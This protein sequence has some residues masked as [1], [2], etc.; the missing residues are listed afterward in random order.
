MVERQKEDLKLIA[1]P[2]KSI[3]QKKFPE[4]KVEN[5]EKTRFIYLH[6]YLYGGVTTFTA[7]LIYKL[8]VFNSSSSISSRKSDIHIRQIPSNNA[9]LRC[10]KVSETKLREFGYGLVYQNVSPSILAKIK[11]PF[12]TIFKENYFFHVL[13][14]LNRRQRDSL[15]DITLVI[16]DHRDISQNTAPYVKNWR[17]VAIRKTV[18][19]YM[20]KRYGLDCAFLY[21]PFY[22][23]PVVYKPKR[24]GAVST[25]RISFEKNTD[26][27]IKANKILDTADVIKLY[28]C[29]S[30]VYV[31]SFLGGFQGDFGKYFYGIFDKSFSTLSE[32]LAEAK[33]VVDLSV[34]KHDGGGTQYSFLEAI[35]NDCALILHRKWIEGSDI[36][37]D[38]RDFKEGYNCFAI[39]NEKELAE[40]IQSDPDT[41]KVVANSKALIQR[42]IEVDWS[43][44]LKDSIPA[45]SSKA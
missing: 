9:I 30:R 29:P 44:L 26:I 13:V 34:L 5:T 36:K 27:I 38:Y 19:E 23:Y 24:R 7:H 18:Q 45:V 42:H 21:H 28:G 43:R 32:I 15:K 8:G 11:Y 4:N 3:M 39:D 40:L 25:T 14:D 35:H 22:P 1:A 2:P 31:H 37:P 12:L 6:K 33:F 17:L 41:S 10:G 16:H 20:Q